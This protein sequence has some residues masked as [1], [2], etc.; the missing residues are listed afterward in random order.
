MSTSMAAHRPCP[1]CG[2]SHAATILRCPETDMVLPLEGRR[3][4]G[5]FVLQRCIGRGGMASVWLARNERV[6]RDV[7]I[8]LIRPEVAR[9]DEL[10]A[11]FRAEARAAGRIGHANICD[12]LDSG[13]SPIGPYIVMERL[14]GRSLGELLAGGQRLEPQLAVTLV[15]DALAGLAA[16]HRAGIV[17]RDLKPENLFLHC[18]DGGEPLVKLMD[19]GVAKF[20]DGTGETQ[21]QHGALLGTPEYMAPEQFRGAALAEPRTDLWAMGAILYRTLGGRN[22]FGGPTVASTLLMVASESP[23]PLREL[24]PEVPEALAAIVERCLQKDPAER[25]A[26]AAALDT[27]LSPWALQGEPRSTALAEL[28]AAALGDEPPAPRAATS[29]DALTRPWD[30]PAPTREHAVVVPPRRRWLGAAAIVGVAGVVAAIAWP[31]GEP[32]PAP[33]AAANAAEPTPLGHDDPALAAQARTPPRAG[34]DA[35]APEPGP[36]ASPMPTISTTT[37]PAPLPAESPPPTAT[38]TAPP[39]ATAD[40]PSPSSPAPVDP[41]GVVREG[42]YV[43]L[44]EPGRPGSHKQAHE[45]C[46]ALA[47]AGHLGIRGWALPN[48]AVATKFV[49]VRALKKARYWTSALWRGKARAVALPSGQQSSLDADGG[50]ARALCVARWP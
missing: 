43:A 32:A 20:T 14:R 36:P 2:Q 13:R 25:F 5:R 26:D 22:A 49:G 42:R 30:K 45:H 29:G 46:E 41:A 39:P 33:V 17:H 11:R 21:T 50:R 9:D 6:D 24:A 4:D 23:V 44:L 27:A 7:A 48:P 37:P 3:L 38:T 35:P 1:H 12:I 8:K 16:A 40:E 15:R 28:R 18:P 31:R 10:V 19:F 47:S 34:D